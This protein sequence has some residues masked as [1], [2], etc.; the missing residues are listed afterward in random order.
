MI[1][2]AQQKPWK[3]SRL[4]STNRM[5]AAPLSQSKRITPRFAGCDSSG[6]TLVVSAL[7]LP[8]ACLRVLDVQALLRGQRRPARLRR[9]RKE[10]ASPRPLCLDARLGRNRF[11]RSSACPAIRSSWPLCFQA[12]RHGELLPPSPGCRS[13][14]NWPAASCSPISRAASRRRTQARRAPCH[15]LARRALPLHSLYAASPLTEGPT[16]FCICAGAVGRGALSANGPAGRPALWLSPSPSPL[17]RCC[18]PMARWP[19][20]LLRLRCSLW[21]AQRATSPAIPRETASHRRW[22]ALCSPS[23]PSPPGP[24]ATG[25]S[26]TSSSRS[27]RATPPI[28]ASRLTPGWQR[29]VKTWCLDFVS[30]YHV[31]LER[32]RRP[33]RHQQAAQPRLRLARAVRRDRR[34][35]RRLQRRNGYRP[36]AADSMRAL[37]RLA[38]R[39]HRRPSAALLPLAAPRPRGRHVAP[40]ARRKPAH[41]PRL[42]GLRASPRRDPLQLG[43]RGSECALSAARRCRASACGRASGAGCW[44]TCCCAAPCCSPSKP[45][46][47]RYTL[48]C[49]PM[50]FALGGVALARSTG[51]VTDNASR[52]AIDALRLLSVF[53]VK[54]SPAATDSP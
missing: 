7:A 51:W 20:S 35:R 3:Q 12:L 6:C 30:T 15:A 14:W 28:P 8:A 49:F 52:R 53:K 11:P 43:L 24:G 1:L 31:V 10:P 42:V 47:A 21:P 26:S 39:A 22:S 27:R 4:Y 9:H 48:E 44:P 5:E 46:E 2:R 37:P 23:R 40:P 50:L 54:A 13:R 32:P 33:A 18:V 25:R 34:A 38:A 29:W 41:R 45:P 36:H 16:L 17:P 19:P